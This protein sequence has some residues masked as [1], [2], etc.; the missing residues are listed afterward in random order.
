MVDEPGAYQSSRWKLTLSQI[1]TYLGCSALSG[2]SGGITVLCRLEPCARECELCVDNMTRPWEE[3]PSEQAAATARLKLNHYITD[4][5]L[6]KV[7]IY[8]FSWWTV[9]LNVLLLS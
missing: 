8:F 1:T 2:W 4:T 3:K 5:F 9:L 7:F 6:I